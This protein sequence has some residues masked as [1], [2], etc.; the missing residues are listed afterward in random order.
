MG[1]IAF[2]T[3][4]G[5]VY[6]SNLLGLFT[7]DFLTLFSMGLHH[8][9]LLPLQ[10]LLSVFLAIVCVFLY[11]RGLKKL[12]RI[13]NTN[14]KTS[15]LEV[16]G[17]LAFLSVLIVVSINSAF[18]FKGLSLDKSAHFPTNKFLRTITPSSFHALYNLAKISTKMPKFADFT[19]KSLETI[20]HERLTNEPYNLKALLT[21]HSTSQASEKIEQVFFIVAE[22][23]SDYYFE[24]LNGVVLAQKLQV[25]LKED[26][27]Y[28]FKPKHFIQG[29]DR[30]IK[31]IGLLVS[32]LYPF[33]ETLMSRMA[34]VKPLETALALQ[35]KPLG[36][37][38]NFFYGGSSNWQNLEKF[39][40]AQGFDK[41]FYYSNIEP[42][43]N[44]H[45]SLYPQPAS[46]NYG[47]HDNVLFD[48]ILDTISNNQKSFNMILT[49]SNHDT[50]NLNLKAFKGDLEVPLDKMAQSIT[51]ASDLQ[52][53][54]TRFWSS[55]VLAH[56]IKRAKEKFPKA[57]FIITGDHFDRNFQMAKGHL[58]TNH[59]IPL[60]V[61]A[62]K[63]VRLYPQQ[64]LGTHMDLIATILE[65][66]TPKNQSY[67][68]FSKPL[69]STNN[70]LKEFNSAMGDNAMAMMFK[71]QLSFYEPS[72][73]WQCSM[74]PHH[75]ELL[76]SCLDLEE[77]QHYEKDFLKLKE[78]QALS[79]H[80]FKHG[81]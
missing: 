9:A 29:T 22:S 49:L 47:F 33:S 54:G 63:S 76:D 4:F 32:G 3:L 44:K 1:D 45:A 48:Y 74:S 20:L 40:L 56:F 26:N 50:Y 80:I 21:H 81:F 46:N 7:E 28:S 78:N 27:V 18:S 35:V 70:T 57:L 17:L 15:F 79:W 34:S 12:E 43:Y 38:T 31:T 41:L 16:G 66:L 68:S 36:Y 37:S 52:S 6:N 24:S 55:S 8:K 72:T 13:L 19:P 71:N 39:V 42:Y 2:Y 5:D 51:N 25:L 30:T 53:M 59:T 77:L 69:F 10:I 62:P 58:E 23:L 11:V 67:L 75:F 64:T 14:T 61:V 60:I 65:L 73:S